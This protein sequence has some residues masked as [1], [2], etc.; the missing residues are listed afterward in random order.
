MRCRKL[1]RIYSKYM[2]G[3]LSQRKVRLVEEH[4]R[5]CPDCAAEV[6]SLERMRSLLRTAGTVEKPDTYWDTYWDRLERKLPDEPSPV[7]LKPRISGFAAALLRQPAVLGRVVIYVLFLAFVIYTTPEGRKVGKPEIRKARDLE[8]MN[9]MEMPAAP[10]ELR[11]AEESA[12]AGGEAALAFRFRSRAIARPARAEP[13]EKALDRPV[14]Y[15]LADKAGLEPKT[16]L[17][18]AGG[19][20]GRTEEVLARTAPAKPEPAPAKSLEAATAG[21]QDVLDS[22]DEYIAADNYFKK[23]EYS[24]AITAYQNF[25]EANV[26]DDRTLKAKYQIGEAYYQIGNYSEAVSNFAAVTADARFQPGSGEEASR[27]FMGKSPHTTGRADTKGLQKKGESKGV[28]VT[29]LKEAEMVSKL[30]AEREGGLKAGRA[31]ASRGATAL[32]SRFQLGEALPET[33]EELISRAI[34]RQAQSYEHL[35]KREDALAKYKEYMEKYPQ[36]KYVSQ[37]KEKITQIAR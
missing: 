6:E 2:D 32:D 34:F 12:G 10:S 29:Q 3:Q 11:E 24:Q 26:D 23:R 21:L 7:T 1:R 14:D 27:A 4:I 18:E 13:A 31:I 19:L 17:P 33:R 20:S 22:E 8:I 9:D 15:D 35:G 37:A 25:I 30:K 16:E 28:G 36:G 5:D